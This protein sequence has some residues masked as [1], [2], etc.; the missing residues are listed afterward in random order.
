MIV[1]ASD[2][3]KQKIDADQVVIAVGIRPDHRIHEQIMLLGYE[4]HV[5]GDCLEPRTAKAAIY[6]GAKLGSKI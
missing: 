6:E 5:I 4:T 3:T 2:G 1:T